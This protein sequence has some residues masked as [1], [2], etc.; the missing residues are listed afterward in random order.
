VC[1]REFF[2]SKNE[3]LAQS[4]VDAAF[5]A[6]LNGLLIVVLGLFV[7]NA[8]ESAIERAERRAALK[9]FKNASLLSSLESITK[10]YE[11]LGCAREILTASEAD[12]K[13]KISM[14]VSV[15]YDRRNLLTALFPEDDF[16]SFGALLSVLDD[17]HSLAPRQAADETLVEGLA[18]GFGKVVNQI[19]NKIE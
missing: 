1:L 6:I 14:F 12:C 2:F 3:T 10:A 4:F 18:D 7:T 16:A 5:K 19:A 9:T 17:L 11:D 8:A 15:L 13:T